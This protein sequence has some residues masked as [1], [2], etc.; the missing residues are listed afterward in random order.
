MEVNDI[1][2]KDAKAQ[3]GILPDRF[4]SLAA[5]CLCGRFQAKATIEYSVK[6]T[7]S[8]LPYC[9]AQTVERGA[10]QCSAS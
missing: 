1:S 8:P 10:P 2:R 6:M 9:R 5:W 7:K 4:E 3:R